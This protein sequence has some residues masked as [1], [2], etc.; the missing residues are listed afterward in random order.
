MQTSMYYAFT[1][2]EKNSDKSLQ[3]TL[4]TTC[5]V[6]HNTI[7]A[8]QHYKLCVVLILMHKIDQMLTM[9]NIKDKTTYNAL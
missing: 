2:E 4:C 1:E 8:A 7:L 5:N 6:N 9:E 3:F